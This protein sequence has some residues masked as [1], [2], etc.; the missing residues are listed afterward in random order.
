MILRVGHRDEPGEPRFKVIEQALAVARPR[1]RS[2]HPL[3][4]L[5]APLGQVC[6]HYATSRRMYEAGRGWPT[7]RQLAAADTDLDAS[8]IAA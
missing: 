2:R 8:A 7:D 6:I 3:R 1:G 5:P 4:H